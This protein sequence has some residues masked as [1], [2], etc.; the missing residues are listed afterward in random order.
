M[1]DSE[2]FL[3]RW[4]RRKHGAATA[5]REEAKAAED[6]GQAAPPP[7]VAAGAL[8]GEAVPVDPAN[9]PP[10]ESIGPGSDVR[11]FLQAGVPAD[12]TRAALRRA[13]SADPD[14]R[15]FVGLAENAW[16]FNAPDGMAGFGPMTADEVRRL[17]EHMTDSPA[18]TGPAQ[19][20]EAGTEAA[21]GAP[22]ASNDGA[23]S[24]AGQDQPRKAQESAAQETAISH[25][26]TEN[27]AAQQNPTNSE[28][29]PVL[30]RRS[31]GGA[32]PQ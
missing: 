8:P 25:S 17:L 11:A 12:L 28:Y 18:G 24:V 23:R 26:D 9:L 16:D 29:E 15:D 30:A 27:A 21:E 20:A 6:A 22:P 3:A 13:W 14:I 2:S 32:V 4:S 1:S 7:T 5:P 10:L 31:H 19:T